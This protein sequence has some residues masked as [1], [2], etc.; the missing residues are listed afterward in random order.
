MAQQVPGRALTAMNAALIE[1]WRHHQQGG[2]LAWARK[3]VFSKWALVPVTAALAAVAISL[4]F[5]SGPS[6]SQA[7]SVV[8]Q[9]V[10]GEMASVMIMQTPETQQTVIWIS[11]ADDNQGNAI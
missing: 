7:P 2:W 1:R 6:V 11:E 4:P 9:S 10:S 3:A 8:I 5:R